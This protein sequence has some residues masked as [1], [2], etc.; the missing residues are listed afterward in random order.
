[1]FGFDRY[2]A[3]G[4]RLL[5]AMLAISLAGCATAYVDDT[6][7]DLTPQE[8]VTVANP[9]PVQLLFD[10]QTKGTHNGRAADLLKNVVTSAVQDSG[11]FSRVGSDP[12]PNGALLNIVINNVPLTDDAF[13]KG[14]ATGLTLGLVGN[15]VGDGYVCTA[16]YV[17]GTN[18]AKITK[19]MRDAIYTSIGA[20]AG[21]P[22]HAQKM[23]GLKEAV[24]TM[25]RQVVSNTLNELAK[26]GAFNRPSTVASK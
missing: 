21:T 5:A 18:G 3:R 2:V 19:S 23:P 16:D 15:T 17:P 6:L 14:F 22:Q 12:A 1:M 7:H 4:A 11:L 13:A 20:T 26:D 24:E 9:Q 8:R 10:F 25:T